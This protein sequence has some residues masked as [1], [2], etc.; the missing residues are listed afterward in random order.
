MK[1]CPKTQT[2]S[3][4]ICDKGFIKGVVRIRLYKI[5][6]IGGFWVIDFAVFR[7]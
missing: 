5:G 2:G 4:N 1:L 7:I 6:E 3:V